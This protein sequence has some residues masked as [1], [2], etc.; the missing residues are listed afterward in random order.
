VPSTVVHV[1]F[2][3]LVAAAVLGAHYD[4]R[5]LLVVVAAVV[6]V[7]LD[8]VTSLVIE[9][10]HRALFHTLLLPLFAGW[11]LYAETRLGDRSVL[12]E[13]HGDRGVR[14]AWAAIG[15][16]TVSAIG[17]DLF[18]PQG[19]NLL[20]P[21]HDQFYSF[22]GNVNVSSRSGVGQSFVEF[23]T[24]EPT[25]AQQGGQPS[26]NVQV[27]VGAKGSTQEYRVG[28][29]IDPSRGREPKNVERVFPVVQRGW[30]LWLVLASV[31]GLVARSRL[32]PGA[33]DTGSD[34]R[35]DPDAIPNT[36]PAASDLRPAVRKVEADGGR[37][38]ES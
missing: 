9:S 31:I 6:F 18:T 21:F 8:T 38:E 5:S 12:R 23:S 2:G 19:V 37:G 22:V 16:M 1:A 27:D 7:D 15:A 10:S 11:F 30:Q 34:P 33:G 29:G 17:L 36:S 20:Y 3:L 14:V 28:S 13:R 26:R 24:P 25:P 32:A 35:Q 4:R